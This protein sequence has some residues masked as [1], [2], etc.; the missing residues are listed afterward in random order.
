MGEVINLRQ[1]RKKRERAAKDAKA[2]EN[3]ASHGLTKSEYMRQKIERELEERR[4][5][6]AKKDEAEE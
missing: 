3:R 4:L 6:G 2:A 1:A 5:Q